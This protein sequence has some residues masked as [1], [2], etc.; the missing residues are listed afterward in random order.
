MKRVPFSLLQFSSWFWSA[1]DTGGR[2]RMHACTHTHTHTHSISNPGG[3]QRQLQK[4]KTSLVLIKPSKFP[5]NTAKE[6]II[7]KLKTTP[8]H[9]PDPSQGNG[10]LV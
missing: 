6:K 1:R 9:S 3:E 4:P 7:S 10:R 5:G 2:A 8:S